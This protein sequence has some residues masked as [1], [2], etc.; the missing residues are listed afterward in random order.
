MKI[1]FSSITFLIVTTFIIFTAN[2]GSDGV[3]IRHCERRSIF[4]ENDTPFSDLTLFAVKFQLCMNDL[5]Y[6]YKVGCKN[7]RIPNCWVREQFAHN[8]APPPREA[9]S[10]NGG[11]A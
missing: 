6:M 4:T 1:L 3:S 2:S 10:R 11:A 9:Q 5:G 7:Q 8:G